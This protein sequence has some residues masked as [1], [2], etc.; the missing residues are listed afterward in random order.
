[1]KLIQRIIIINQS[2]KQL[3]NRNIQSDNEQKR[4]KF[5]PFFSS[6]VCFTLFDDFQFFFSFNCWV[7]SVYLSL[8]PTL[9]VCVCQWIKFSK[10]CYYL[11]L[12]IFEWLKIVKERE[13]ERKKTDFNVSNISRSIDLII[14]D[15]YAAADMNI[16][17]RLYA[18]KKR[19]GGFFLMMMVMIS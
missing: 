11:L 2:I 13:R 8:S 9:S 6:L 7:V 17:H 12:L 16:N 3:I 18:K 10:T 15:I 4:R 14:N 5:D 1:M 19:L